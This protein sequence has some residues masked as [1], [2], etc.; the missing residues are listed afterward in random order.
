MS[1][2]KVG[3]REASLV[4]AMLVIL[5]VLITAAA[6]YRIR[7]EKS[8]FDRIDSTTLT[9]F[10]IAAAVLLLRDVKS[11]S[12]GNTKV[13]F[14][15]V[16]AL[17]AEAKTA[18]ENAQA[19]AIGAGRSDAA[20]VMKEFMGEQASEVSSADPWKGRFGGEAVRDGRQLH[21]DVSPLSG[22]SDIFRIHLAVTST[23]PVKRPLRGAVQFFL[24]PTFAN[25]TP[26]VKVSPA[27][28]A[29]L[30]LNAW[31]AFTVGVIAD[32]GATRLELDLAQL[33]TA[34]HEFRVR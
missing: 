27:G 26:V 8:T 2:R 12:F 4:Q 20:G 3:G 22:T 15:R 33:P 5:S 10:A 31:G 6:I 1:E 11:F 9:Y 28:T 13:E 19:A 7:A 30:T 25:N 34:P 23:D 32:D 21:A 18:A 16:R 14:E 24:H 17:A 29:E